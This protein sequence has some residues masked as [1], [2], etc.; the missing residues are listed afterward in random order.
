MRLNKLVDLG[1]FTEFHKGQIIRYI[2]R[3]EENRILASKK[4]CKKMKKKM[5]RKNV[6]I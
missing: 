4:Q 5:L 2:I 3:K 6:L 1:L